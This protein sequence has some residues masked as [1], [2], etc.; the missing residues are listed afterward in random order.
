MVDSEVFVQSD[1]WP[2]VLPGLWMCG[3]VFAGF[4][5]AVSMSVEVWAWLPW[6]SH[7]PLPAN[8]A[9]TTVAKMQRE[10]EREERLS[11]EHIKT[12]SSNVD[13]WR[14]PVMGLAHCYCIKKYEASC[15]AKIYC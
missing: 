11:E 3:L 8:R 10:C 9:G 5:P 1:L 12:W 14:L 13:E 6:Q 7:S 15:K 4:S 2:A